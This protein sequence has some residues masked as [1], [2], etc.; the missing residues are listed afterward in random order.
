[1]KKTG[2]GIELRKREVSEEERA[3]KK[4]KEIERREKKGERKK[5]R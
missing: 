5:N 3:R 2:G 4:G 1:M